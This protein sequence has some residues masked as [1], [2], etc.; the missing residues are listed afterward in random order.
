MEGAT[1]DTTLQAQAL[2][3]LAD[4]LDG[5]YLYD[6]LA[7]AEKDAR[8]AEVY[9]RMAEAERKHAAAWTKRLRDAGALDPEAQHGMAHCGPGVVR[10]PFRAVVR[11][12][13]DH[14]HGTE[15]LKEIRR[16]AGR[17]RHGRG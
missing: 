10:P 3:S 1:M 17:V 13:D 7:V 9:H 15:G 8:L 2:A 14:G 12:A 4:E 11:A 16:N 6:A 5:A